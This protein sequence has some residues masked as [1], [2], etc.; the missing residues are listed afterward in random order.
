M[1]ASDRRA[2]SAPRRCG[3]YL[4]SS[5]DAVATGGGSDE[6]DDKVRE[7]LLPYQQPASGSD[8]AVARGRGAVPPV[9]LFRSP[10]AWLEDSF[11]VDPDDHLLGSFTC[12]LVANVHVVGK[13]FVVGG[14]RKGRGSR[15]Y[16][17]SNI[18]RVVTTRTIDLDDVVRVTKV[19]NRVGVL[20]AIEILRRGV[21]KPVVFCSLLYRENAFRCILDAWKRPAALSSSET[22]IADATPRPPAASPPT[23]SPSS[24]PSPSG[25]GPGVACSLG[26]TPRRRR[27]SAPAATLDAV[28]WG[29]AGARVVLRVEFPNHDARHV[30][31]TVFDPEGNLLSRHL[32][33]NC[34]ATELRV[35]RQT[36]LRDGGGEFLACER[37]ASYLA[38]VQYSFPN[39]PTHCEV[40]DTQRYVTPRANAPG[41]RPLAM[42]SVASTRGAPFADT[43]C[44]DSSVRVATRGERGCVVEVLCAV[45]WKKPVNG[46]IRKL[47]V[48]GARDQL[49]RSYAKMLAMAS[50]DLSRHDEDDRRRVTRVGAAAF[51]RRRSPSLDSIATKGARETFGSV[52][53]VGE[54]SRIESRAAEKPSR[55]VEE[56]GVSDEAK[57]R[58]APFRMERSPR[59][60]A[61]VIPALILLTVAT[62]FVWRVYASIFARGTSSDAP[63]RIQSCDPSPCLVRHDGLRLALRMAADD[64]AFVAA[65][66]TLLEDARALSA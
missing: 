42:R 9:P 52:G 20:S 56:P 2:R 60:G 21:D 37:F 18:C 15:A 12:A 34:G 27:R 24:S 38:P 51:R 44:V 46:I 50:A 65:L 6:D 48:R 36:P 43:F 26:S 39:L 30:F 40:H 31:H 58:T 32:R 35:S 59:N 62:F 28:D 25:T 14:G 11:D 45:D 16:F 53:S 19:K 13:L 10:A 7:T 55:V 64:D 41:D 22:A 57:P 54:S 4:A 33:E 29:D 8:P 49:R 1:F 47:V 63:G 17:F 3:E 5:A 23:P 61:W 66:A